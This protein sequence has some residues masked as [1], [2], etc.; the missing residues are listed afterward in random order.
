MVQHIRPS[1]FVITYGPGA[2]LETRNGPRIILKIEHG[3]PNVKYQDFEIADLRMSASLGGKVFRLPTNDELGKKP[4]DYVYR[5]R[6]FPEWKV[7]TNRS[8]HK[9]DFDTIFSKKWICPLCGNRKVEAI[10]F[11]VA[12]SAGHLDDF[13]WDWLVHE[14]SG[15]HRSEY[16]IWRGAGGSLSDAT[17]ECPECN[18]KCPLSEA[19]SKK[20]TCSGR[21]PEDEPGGVSPQR[22]GCKESARITLRQ[23]SNLRIP[24]IRTLFS[25]LPQMNSRLHMVLQKK[26]VQEVV[27]DLEEALELN[28]MNVRPTQEPA[29]LEKLRKLLENREKGNSI[30]QATIDFIFSFPEEEIMQALKDIR[31]LSQKKTYRELIG[32]EFPALIKASYEGAPPKQSKRDSRPF[33][34]VDPNRVKEFKAAGGWTFRVTPVLSLRAVIVQVGYRREVKT[35]NIGSGLL[36]LQGELVEVCAKDMNGDRWY[37]GVES[38]G[39]GVFISMAEDDWVELK[40]LQ[41]KATGEWM[42]AFKGGEDLRRLYLPYLF[43]DDQERE[44]MHPWFVWWHTLSHA[45]IRHISSEAGYSSASIR[46]R[47][48]IERNGSRFRGGILLYATSLGSE[49][50]LGGLVGLV[51]HFEQFFKDVMENIRLC[52]SDPLCRQQE[53]QRGSV[54]G[55]ACYACLYLSETSCEHRNMWLDRHVVMENQP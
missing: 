53:F 38:Y 2:I 4:S 36:Q 47:V 37:P 7:C 26:V 32:G 19:Y 50:T 23:S 51:P 18:K 5:T 16:L 12:C 30:D 27:D 15:G 49:G 33:F 17:L 9:G 14:G 20:K 10:R 21:F 6:A 39:E 44:E 41:G 45:L 25:I 3:L 42:N 35:E 28:I 31:S 52:S 43:R 29:Y 40:R 8:G 11:I 48:Y 24:E 55:A 34:H 13:D 46:E 1:Q 22:R 54:N